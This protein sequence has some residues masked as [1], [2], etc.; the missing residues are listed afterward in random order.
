M[1]KQYSLHMLET[2]INAAL[3][4]DEHAAEKF[5]GIDGKIL[6]ILV[7][8]LNFSIFMQFSAKGI[9]LLPT[10]NLQPDATIVSHPLG[11][12]RLSVLPASQ[13]RSLFHDGVRVEGD[14]EF[15][16]QVKIIFDELDLDWEGSLARFTG[17]MVAYRIA[18]TVHSVK[19]FVEHSQQSATFQLSSYLHEELAIIPT[20]EEMRDFFDE[21]D[22]LALK[23]ERLAAKI[24]MRS[25][26]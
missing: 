8:P 21:I 18:S 7:L 2:T 11:L 23:V 19:R 6:K 4:L 20:S 12:I 22:E 10:D 14:V 13:A 9:Q 3:K 17:D 26:L 5:A 25:P 15:A 1:L 24:N 16:Q